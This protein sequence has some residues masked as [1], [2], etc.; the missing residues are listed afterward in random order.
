[1]S[2]DLWVYN[3]HPRIFLSFKKDKDDNR[4]CLV[5]IRDEGMWGWFSCYTFECFKEYLEKYGNKV[6]IKQ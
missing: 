6:E 3:M 4:F 5:D 1:M 2:D